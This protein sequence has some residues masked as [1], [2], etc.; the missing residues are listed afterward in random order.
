MLLRM[1]NIIAE[2]IHILKYFK[3]VLFRSTEPKNLKIFSILQLTSSILIL[4]A[5]LF[6]CVF[7]GWKVPQSRPRVK[8]Y[9]PNIQSNLFTFA[10]EIPLNTLT[11]TLP[12]LSFQ[13]AGVSKCG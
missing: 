8:I 7:K 5:F 2:R 9:P 10:A 1:K 13:E 4:E 6:E 11:Y 12:F 3:K